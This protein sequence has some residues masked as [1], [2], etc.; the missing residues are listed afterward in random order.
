M[1]SALPHLRSLEVPNLFETA[2]VQAAFVA[3]AESYH[4]LDALEPLGDEAITFLSKH[5]Q[6]FI[7]NIWMLTSIIG[8]VRGK[9]AYN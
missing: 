1:P 6:L 2:C 3:R 9:T 8:R 7:L 4:F 5:D